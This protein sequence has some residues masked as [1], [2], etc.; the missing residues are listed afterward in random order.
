MSVC[1][2]IEW[3]LLFSTPCLGGMPGKVRSTNMYMALYRKWRP[4]TFEDVISQPHITQ[5]LKN[6]IASQ[7]TAHAYLFTGSRGTGKTTC[8][9]ILA[10]AVNCLHPVDGNPCLECEVCKGIE[11][12]SI[13][14]V[15]EIDAASNNGVDNIRE[16][17][18]EALYTPAVC[19][20]R[21]YIIDETHMLSPGA[22]N[23]LLKIMEEPPPHVKFILATT[24]VH[25][26]PS[27]I[28]SRCQRYD[29]RR[30]RSEDISQRLTY[31]SSQE[32]IALSESGAA[33]IAKLADGGMR[34]ALS[35]LDQCAAVS[36]NVG[37]DEISTVCGIA[38][39]DYLFELADAILACDCAKA[40]TIIDNLY[41]MSKDLTR[42]CEELIGHFRNLMMMKSLP[43]G[44]ELVTCLPD[45][46]QQMQTAARST[47]MPLIL[48]TLTVLQE[49]LDRLGRTMGKRI[50]LEMCM[51]RLCNPS[52]DTSQSALLSRIEELE[53]VVRSGRVPKA[54]PSSAKTPA[55][56]SS[57][58]DSNQV[59][60]PKARAHTQ[61]DPAKLTPL[62]CWAE[63]LQTLGELDKAMSGVLQ[64]STAFEFE[65]TVFIDATNSVIASSLIRQEN[66]SKNL[67]EALRI[68]TGRDYFIR[69]KTKPKQT[70]DAPSSLDKLIQR[71]NELG[72]DTTVS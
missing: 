26:V 72:V 71:A 23:A 10:K 21:V 47:P 5:T 24:E 11:D 56:P 69:I 6:Q 59:P 38:G 42:L 35:I 51:V 44:T 8:A 20:F 66:F 60:T 68:H 15:V 27:T 18:E 9:K 29:F 61:I 45:E 64:N 7:S 25:K 53:R 55:P 19:R 41:G 52:L 37:V 31:V 70:A 62:P 30:I 13:L 12:G 48:H 49:C 40:L 2:I 1:E 67:K 4:K 36:E 32:G 43:D 39:R 50:E 63:V 34:D 54:S 3:V 33:L 16:L 57:I 17:R 14:D 65:N 58:S 22:F 46:L 28:L